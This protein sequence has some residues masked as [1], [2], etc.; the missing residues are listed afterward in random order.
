MSQSRARD[1]EK[2]W[3]SRDT[4]CLD[5]RVTKNTLVRALRIMASII[6][7][8]ERE[9][10]KVAVETKDTESTRATI[11][12]ETIRFGLIERSRQIKPT[13]NP[14]GS[15]NSY[16]PVRLEPTGILSV[17]VWNYYSGGPQ[18]VWRDR[19]NIKLEELVS[20]CVAGMMR[21]AL[22]ERADAKA[23]QERE[24][25]HRKKVAEVEAE[26]EKIRAEERRIKLLRRDAVAW[27]RAERIRKYIAVV[28]ESGTK[29]VEWLV[30]AESQADRLNPLKEK[31]K[32][33][34]DDKEEVL[35]RL[36][37][38]EWGW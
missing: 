31:P 5:L 18:K 8:L 22:K 35:K 3:A 13:P 36:H 14:S 29:D 24:L 26:L 17:E 20:K 30:W 2:L 25:A 11:Y 32:S 28:R 37:E 33:I 4:E 38:V 23:R 12:G 9:G 15:P 10:F 34:A 6:H 27:H 19:E 1:G 16:N 7:L 21:I